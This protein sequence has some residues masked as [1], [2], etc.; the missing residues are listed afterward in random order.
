MDTLH[1]Q[2]KMKLTE[3]NLSQSDLARELGISK[4]LL[5]GVLTGAIKS[6]PVDIKLIQ[7]LR[8]R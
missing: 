1:T 2:I 8:Q 3:L 7:W 4:Q 5:S 6:L